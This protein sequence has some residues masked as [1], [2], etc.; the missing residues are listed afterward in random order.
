MNE[1][2][3]RGYAVYGVDGVLSLRGEYA[4]ATIKPEI[5]GSLLSRL[6]DPF[7]YRCPTTAFH[8]LCIKTK[9]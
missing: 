6:S 1:F 9:S 8:L 4:S 3:N 5:L 7:V 2:S